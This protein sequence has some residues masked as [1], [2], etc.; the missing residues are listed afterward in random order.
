MSA[1]ALRRPTCQARSRPSDPLVVGE[2]ERLAGIHGR[3][4]RAPGLI[5]GIHDHVALQ[6]QSDVELGTQG[7]V[8]QRWIA[9]AE[10]DVGPPPPSPRRFATDST[11]INGSPDQALTSATFALDAATH[12]IAE[13]EHVRVRQRVANKESVLLA[14]HEARRVQH[15]QVFGRVCL[16]HPGLLRELRHRHA[17]LAKAHEQVQSRRVREGAKALGDQRENLGRQFHRG[18]VTEECCRRH[19]TRVR[20]RGGRW[21]IPRTSGN[22]EARHASMPPSRFATLRTPRAN[23][24]LVAMADRAPL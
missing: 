9:G 13:L 6:E 14:L 18:E 21:P 7:A 24:T 20:S 2:L 22:L 23:S 8:C 11:G 1:N 4:N 3:D 10:D 5:G 12:D 19:A 17:L 16:V 15:L